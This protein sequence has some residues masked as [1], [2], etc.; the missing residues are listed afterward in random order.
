MLETSRGLVCINSQFLK[1][2]QGLKEGYE[3][4]ERFS[5]KQGIYIAVKSG[6]SLVG[7]I[8]PLK[9]IDDKFVEELERVFELAECA[10]NFQTQGE[11]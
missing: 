11:C 4:Y 10:K 7:I 5:E 2:F 6:F 3:L 8:L 9:I 1:P